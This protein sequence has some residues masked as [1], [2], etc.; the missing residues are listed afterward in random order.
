MQGGRQF[1]ILVP[2]QIISGKFKTF[3][4]SLPRELWGLRDDVGNTILHYACSY[5]NNDMDALKILLNS[6]LIDIDAKNMHHTTAAHLAASAECDSFKLLCA[7]G[8]NLCVFNGFSTPIQ[9]AFHKA[10]YGFNKNAH[11]ALAY[12]FRDEP[13]MPVHLKPFLEQVLKCKSICITLLA[14]KRRRVTKLCS[15]DRFLV[16]ELCLTIWAA[17]NTF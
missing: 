17:K 2:S 4:L 3:L 5:R 8:A 6:G 12:G 9:L 1:W 11:I 14:L 16:K 10:P 7:A 15:V 13:G